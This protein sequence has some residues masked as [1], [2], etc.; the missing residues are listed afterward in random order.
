MNR[1]YFFQMGGYEILL[2]IQYSR[3][4]NPYPRIFLH[5]PGEEGKYLNLDLAIDA[6][7]KMKAKDFNDWKE[8]AEKLTGEEIDKQLLINGINPNGL[9]EYL[10]ALT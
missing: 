2:N 1:T 3:I 6:A 4:G 7:F 10:S 9:R 5:L 8:G